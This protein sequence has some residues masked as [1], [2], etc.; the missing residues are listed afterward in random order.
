MKTN[1]NPN[2]ITQNRILNCI[3][4]VV[5]I[6]A[7]ACASSQGQATPT[8]T[9]TG[10]EGIPNPASVFCSEQG[11]TLEVR[12]DESGGQSGYCLFPDGSECEEW[13]YY[14]GECA[15]A[16][17]GDDSTQPTAIPTPRPID[18]E[19]YQGWWTY[20]HPVYGFSLML[21]EDWI[22]EEVS[23]SDELLSGHALTLHPAYGAGMESIRMT[24][25]RSGE[26][27]L[28]WP[29]GVGQGEFIEQG[30][31]EVAGEAAR[32]ILLVCPAGEVTEIWY[33]GTGDQVNITRNDLEFAFIFTA[34]E[35][36]TA[37]ASLAGKVQYTGEM[38]IASLQIP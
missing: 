4:L 2:T 14:R 17:E 28:L 3:V 29:T 15:P 21:P 7:A 22:V 27:F 11:Y 13:A 26:D 30:T 6:G 9:A 36:C 10:Q 37:G 31:L 32:R 8:A 12:S 23:T 38:I 1:N 24:F 18:P 34:G 19:D 35:H 20:N 5:L 25:R 16:G 33:H